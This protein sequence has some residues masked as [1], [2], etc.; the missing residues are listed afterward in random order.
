MVD[1][2]N[3]TRQVIELL[4][5]IDQLLSTLYIGQTVQF[6]SVQHETI[7]IGPAIIGIYSTWEGVI[8]NPTTV[9]ET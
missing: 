4:F 6:S 2:L 1:H 5:L 9:H 8:G 7:I 3:L